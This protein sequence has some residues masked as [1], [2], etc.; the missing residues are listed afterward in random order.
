MLLL[1]VSGCLCGDAPWLS[2]QR[3][4]V[5]GTAEG[6]LFVVTT[7]EVSPAVEAEQIAFYNPSLPGV[8]EPLRLVHSLPGMLDPPRLAC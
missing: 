8:L 2:L 1:V 5:L 6:R 7:Q 4:C 3:G